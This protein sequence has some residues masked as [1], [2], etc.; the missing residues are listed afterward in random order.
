MKL[1]Y[2]SDEWRSMLLIDIDAPEIP[3]EFFVRCRFLLGLFPT[4]LLP[5]VQNGDILFRLRRY[6]STTNWHVV[7][8]SN[9]LLLSP[10]ETVLLQSLLGSDPRREAFNA[11]RAMLIR[12]APREWRTRWNVLYLPY[13]EKEA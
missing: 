12:E 9:R 2:F 5:F 11:V 6:R 8:E 4:S 10:V 3:H 7:I 13:M 1:D